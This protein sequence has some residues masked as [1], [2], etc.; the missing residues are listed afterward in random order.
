[1]YISFSLFFFPRE[2][3]DGAGFHSNAFVKNA[4]FTSEKLTESYSPLSLENVSAFIHKNIKLSCFLYI[5]L[6]FSLFLSL[7]IS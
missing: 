4:N 5:A 1:L 6:Y 7:P 2:D 3:V